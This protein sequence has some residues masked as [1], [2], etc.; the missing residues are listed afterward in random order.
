MAGWLDGI[1][2]SSLRLDLNSSRSQSPSGTETSSHATR[3]G[4]RGGHAPPAFEPAGAPFHGVARLLS[5]RV[6][7]LGVRAPGSG[8]HDGLN[9]L[10]ARHAR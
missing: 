1:S 3:M 6:V 4:H 7:G 9:A 8:G 10:R 2:E 5:F